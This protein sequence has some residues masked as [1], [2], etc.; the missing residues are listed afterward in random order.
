MGL[1]SFMIFSGAVLV[2]YVSNNMLVSVVVTICL[3]EY[4]L[5]VVKYFSYAVF[6]FIRSVLKISFVPKFLKKYVNYF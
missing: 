3:V 1:N 6:L 2:F 4:Y 5:I